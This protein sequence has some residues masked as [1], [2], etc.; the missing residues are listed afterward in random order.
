MVDFERS[1]REPQL[2][3]RT[4]EISQQ[5]EFPRE[6]DWPIGAHGPP[7]EL[8]RDLRAAARAAGLLAPQVAPEWGGL[9]LNH[10]E[11]AVVLRAAGYSLLGPLAMNCMAPDEGNMALL[12]RVASREQKEL[13]LRPLAAGECRSAFLMTEPDPGAGSD[14]DMLLTRARR[15]GDDWVIDGRKWFST[16]ADGARFAIIMARTEGGAT[17][18]LADMAAPGIVVERL[19]PT[20][21]D[22]MP[23]GHGVVRLEGVRVPRDRV[24]GEVDQGFRYA[25][26]RLAPARLTHCMRWWG[27]AKRAHDVAV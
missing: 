21:G 9:G 18:F 4:Q 24:L 17:M 15:V 20:L 6:R 26:L 3:Q 7:P 13:F 25:Q 10:R 16:G 27:A 22:A 23:G 8:L 12:E 1:D 5:F 19:L 11:T 14:P 2:E